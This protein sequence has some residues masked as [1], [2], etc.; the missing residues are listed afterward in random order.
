MPIMC[1]GTL[2]TLRGQLSVGSLIAFFELVWFI[3][4][5]VEQL[6]GVVPR[7]QQAAAGLRR[8]QALLAERPDVGDAPGAEAL[9]PLARG[10]GFHDVGF[11]YEGSSP[12]LRDISVTI[13]VRR[14]VAIVGPSGCGKSTMQPDRVTVSCWK[15]GALEDVDRCPE[16]SEERHHQE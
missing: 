8:I 6:A 5:A 14:S 3:V 10:I 15:Q 7:F 12:I 1:V 13:P 2:L 4:S 16:L 9:A 11:G